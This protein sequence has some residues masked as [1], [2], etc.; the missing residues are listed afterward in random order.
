MN[1]KYYI[2]NHGRL[3]LCDNDVMQVPS[4]LPEGLICEEVR[5]FEETTATMSYMARSE[6]EALP[7]GYVWMDLRESFYHLPER[8]YIKAGKAN[9]LLYFDRQHQY[10]GICGSP[11]EWASAISKRCTRCGEELWPKLSTAIIVL[12]RRSEKALLVKAKNFRRDYY[13]LVAGFVETGETL[14]ECV[15]RE[16]FEETGLKVANIRYFASQPW[17]YPMGLMI[18]FQADYVEGDIALR[19]GELCDAA[20]FTRD[21]IPAIPGKMSMAR[22]LIDDWLAQ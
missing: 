16:V 13:G 4:V 12:V 19:D 1:N 18:G 17:P 14:E 11:M 10:C 5:I 21:A 15:A 3:L 2:F 6:Q 7:E 8:A 20:F 22:M 9:E